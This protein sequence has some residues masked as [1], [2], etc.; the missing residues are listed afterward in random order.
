MRLNERADPNL[1]E[2]NLTETA[3]RKIDQAYA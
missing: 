1:R 3:L 2:P